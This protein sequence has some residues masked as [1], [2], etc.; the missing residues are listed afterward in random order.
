[1][2]NYDFH[3]LR[4]EHQ[5]PV[6]ALA[7][8]P[9]VTSPQPFEQQA[10][11]FIPTHDLE[12]AIHAALAL[13]RPLL[14]SGDSG[15]G[16]TQVAYHVAQQLGLALLHFRS[17]SHSQL[18]DVLY[19]FDAVRYEQERQ[20]AAQNPNAKLPKK[21][22]YVQP[23]LLW[24]ALRSEQ[25]CVLLIDDIDVAPRAFAHDWLPI[26]D[27]WSFFIKELNKTFS[28]P[29]EKRPLLFFTS[30]QEKALPAAFLRRCVHHAL[31]FSEELGQYIID[32]HRSA[33]PNLDD[34]LLY[35]A[36]LRF[37]RL[38]A[39][40]L[41]KLPSVAELLDWLR[42]LS[43]A[44]GSYEEPLSEDLAYLP[45]LGVLLKE[46]DDQASLMS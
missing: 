34:A 32:A 26:L 41:Y 6:D 16:K 37:M 39:L 5:H 18:Q 17:T 22:H 15:L 9:C 14:L 11:H 23:K 42:V 24:Q 1:M 3:L 8:R 43:L 36:L 29:A 12:D 21:S 7:Q 13:G 20:H 33:Y 28:A 35:A 40:D 30:H 10:A 4:A 27:D 44:R 25:P 31:N 38:R 46:A 19:D 45:F 2:N